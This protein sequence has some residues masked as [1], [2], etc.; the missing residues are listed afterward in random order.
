MSHV[1]QQ[2]RTAVVAA[3]ESLG[4]VHASR[5]YPISADELP[6]YLVYLGDESIDGD[7]QTLTRT[8]EVVVEVVTAGQ[9]FDEAAED[10]IVAVEQ[11]LTGDLSGLVIALRPASISLSMS[12]EGDAP[13]GR[14]RIAF[15]ALYRTSYTNPE[16]SI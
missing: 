2:I 12:A 8:L 7:F 5:V 10:A 13:I 11:R 9:T 16:V 15:E 4:G 14:A 3:L 6:V 1:R